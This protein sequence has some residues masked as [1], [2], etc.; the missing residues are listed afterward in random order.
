M[1]TFFRIQVL[2]EIL[3][4]AL[5]L[6]VALFWK[7]PRRDSLQVF[8]RWFPQSLRHPAAV[9][10]LT[11]LLTFAASAALTAFTGIPEPR[12]HDEFSYLL[13]GDTFA[14]G[15]LANPPHPMWKHFETF[16]VI[17]QP[18]Y[19]SKYSPGQGLMLALGQ[20]A[21]GHPIVGVWL[22]SSL[23]AAA[24]C[25]MLAGWCPLPWAWLGG[26]IAAIHLVFLGPAGLDWSNSYWGGSVAAL[27]GA[28]VF[29]AL[30]RI[31]KKP[32]WRDALWLTLGLAILANSRPF[33]GLVVSLPV[34]A[35]L[36]IWL[37]RTDR[38]SRPD[39]CRQIVLP[40]L[41]G[42]LLTAVWMGFYNF[43][44]TGD[45][46]RLPYQVYE[47]AYDTVP[48]FFWQS[49]KPAQDYCQRI[50]AD[51]YG[52]WALECFQQSRNLLCWL[53]DAVLRVRFLWLFFFGVLF[54]PFLV[55]ALP[56][57]WRRRSVKFALAVWTLLIAGL[58]METWFWPHYAAPAFSLAILLMV[59]SLRQVRLF[60]WRGRLVGSALVSAI[61]PILLVSSLALVAVTR[62]PN[63]V[64]WSV[65]RT[66]ILQDLEKGEGRHLVLVRY[67]P[68]HCAHEQWIYNRADI[69]AAKV[70]WAAELSPEADRKLLEYFKDRRIWLLQAD[71]EPRHLIPHPASSLAAQ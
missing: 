16:H 38:S 36:G 9:I 18:T 26:L 27:G 5:L 7:N 71:Q 54:T 62:S 51:F 22:S 43:R 23:A 31:L 55:A 59:E 24:T 14:Q 6:L 35:G 33:E 68:D 17:Q 32:H 11:G 10:L 21:F 44:V 8:P 40:T 42:L 50:F 52:G 48:L 69:D 65:E 41:L 53:E 30:P 47:A 58:L 2:I 3:G 60:T 49:L 4:L 57:M 19:A 56:W 28:L 70:V 20:G 45:P 63:W 13:A 34:A 29:G 12:I 25:W 1:A 67:G 46:V 37:L 66:R 64:D 39:R 15:R 61:L